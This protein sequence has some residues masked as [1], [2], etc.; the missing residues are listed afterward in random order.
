MTDEIPFSVDF[1]FLLAFGISKCQLLK[2]QQRRANSRVSVIFLGFEKSPLP[3][4]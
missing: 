3:S 4:F 1:S 2:N